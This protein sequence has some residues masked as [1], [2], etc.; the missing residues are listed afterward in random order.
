MADGLCKVRIELREELKGPT[1]PEAL[2]VS[3]WHYL[4][5]AKLYSK[6]TKSMSLK[7]S[8]LEIQVFSSGDSPLLFLWQSL[9][10]HVFTAPSHSFPYQF[11]WWCLETCHGNIDLTGVPPAR[12]TGCTASHPGFHSS[13]PLTHLMAG[14]CWS[15]REG[16]GE[17]IYN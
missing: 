5:A 7:K 9:L 4:I 8:H 10:A 16:T 3:L 2:P 13:S 17:Q 14:G 15:H 11:W 12:G 6:M 1:G